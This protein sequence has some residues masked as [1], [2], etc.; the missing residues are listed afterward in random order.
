MTTMCMKHYN[1]IFLD[2]DDTLYDTHG[3]SIIALRKLYDIRHWERIVPSYEAFRDAYFATNVEVWK[4]YAHGVMD[5]DTL[6]V[7][8]YRRPVTEM[9]KKCGG[10]TSWI[11]PEWCVAASDQYG[12]IISQ[13]PGIV[14]G[15]RELLTYLTDKGYRLHLCSNG[16]HEVQYRKLQSSGLKDF[17]KTVVLSEDAGVNK[18]RKEF[19]DYTF[20]VTGAK[21]SATIL[22]GDNYDTDITG[23]LNAGID[24][25]LFNRWNIDVNELQRKPTYVVDELSKIEDIL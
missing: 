2:F 20:T 13:E 21:S 7:E 16:F 25:I 23:A 9:V 10:D 15:A 3:N 8:R 14:T 17:F 6:I 11:T 24:S 4:A 22:I 1:D 18:P 5:R 12:D 19:F